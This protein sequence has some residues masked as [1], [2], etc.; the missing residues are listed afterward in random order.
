MTDDEIVDAI[1]TKQEHRDLLKLLQ[2]DLIIESDPKG[3]NKRPGSGQYGRIR[4]IAAYLGISP[5]RVGQLLLKGLSKMRVEYKRRKIKGMFDYGQKYRVSKESHPK[6]V[7]IYSRIP[8][9]GR[10]KTRKENSSPDLLI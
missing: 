6:N 8:V 9:Q 2:K 7:M 3:T 1:L 4:E 10:W 5:Q